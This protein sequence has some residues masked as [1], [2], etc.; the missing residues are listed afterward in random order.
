MLEFLHWHL[1]KGDRLDCA[2]A[3]LRTHECRCSAPLFT[4][5][6]C[7]LPC[8]PILGPASGWQEHISSSL[9]PG[10][11]MYRSCPA[12]VWSLPGLPADGEGKPPGLSADPAAR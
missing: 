7:A 4:P 3:Y 1:E 2:L 9:C 8:T 5:K 12:A 6:R 11:L 10:D